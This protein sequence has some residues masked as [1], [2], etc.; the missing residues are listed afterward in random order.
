MNAG[1]MYAS[2]TRSISKIRLIGHANEY[3]KP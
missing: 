2:M 3:N 1:R